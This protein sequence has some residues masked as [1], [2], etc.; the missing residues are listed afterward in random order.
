MQLKKE[1]SRAQISLEFLLIFAA[2]VAF[3]GLFVPVFHSVLD[4]SLFALDLLRAQHFADSFSTE[5]FDL[6]VQGAGSFATVPAYPLSEWS[7]LVSG[8]RLGV[9]VFSK[10]GR[11]RVLTRELGVA[12]QD[13]VAVWYLDHAAS[14]VLRVENGLLTVNQQ[15]DIVDP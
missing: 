7:V 14:F 1:S 13:A 9:T 8:P 5:S 4:E 3:M 15:S 11:S 6:R 10:S 12:S 2:L